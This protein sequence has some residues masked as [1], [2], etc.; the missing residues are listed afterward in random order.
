VKDIALWKEGSKYVL[1]FSEAAKPVGPL[2]LVP[3]P[4]GIVKAPQAPR[5]T[6]YARLM[7]ATTLDDAF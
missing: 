4:H 1:N 2:K 6:S 3:K 5:Y 7:K